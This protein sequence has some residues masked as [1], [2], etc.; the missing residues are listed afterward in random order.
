MILNM[1][2]N[3]LCSSLNWNS[4]LK[5]L[6]Y[7]GPI[8][9]VE[10]L[11]DANI[12]SLGRLLWV[13]P[14]SI[15]KSP[16][17]TRFFQ[18]KEG[19][20][21]RGIGKIVRYQSRPNFVMRGNKSPNLENVTIIVQDVYSEEDIS[22]VWFNCYKSVSN[23]LRHCN[24]IVFQGKVRIYKNSF[25]IT[26]PTFEEVVKDDIPSLDSLRE[27]NN[28]IIRYP[29]IN[30]VQGNQIKKIFDAIPPRPWHH[31]EDHVP[32]DI[33]TKRSLLPLGESFQ[34]LHGKSC[35]WSEDL[36]GKAK[37]RMIYQ[38][39]FDEQIKIL[40][41]KRNNN[42]SPS[43]PITVSDKMMKEFKA[44]FP[45]VLT[46][47][48]HKAVE[49]IRQ[50]L[51]SCRPMMRLIQGDVGCGKT[52]VAV[53][54]ALMVCANQHQSALMCP[55]ESLAY[56]HFLN[57]SDF[58]KNSPYKVGL[59][60]GST[61]LKEKKVLKQRL[62]E[63]EIHLI[64]GTHSLIQDSVQFQSLALAVIDEQHKFGVNQRV[65]LLQKTSGCHCLIMSATPIPRS[66]RLTQYGDLDITTIK[67]M[68][69]GRRG[70][71]TRIVT[72]KTFRQ[73]LSFVKT[74]LSMGEQGLVVVPTIEES[75]VLDVENLEKTLSEYSKL[76]F[77]YNVAG[78]HGQLKAQE[79]QEIFQNFRYHHID[80]LVAT[81]VVEV[82]I[83]VPNA[84]VMSILNPERFGLS[85]LHQLRGRIG[86]GEKMGFCFLVSSNFQSLKRLRIVE[87]YTDGLK[88]AEEDLK[89]RGEGDLFGTTQS[90]EASKR[91]MANIV[92]HQREL[93]CAR[94]DVEEVIRRD[95]VLYARSFQDYGQ[96]KLVLQTI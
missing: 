90:G 88:I 69:K 17:V 89:I 70:Y 7:K 71:K 13:F 79:K 58:L 35:P 57:I 80:L 63:G 64:V 75:D 54:A 36:L 95:P 60:V 67:T 41:R 62:R 85:S 86:R 76:F 94:E 87:K 84:T 18:L 14:N 6:P 50:D 83:D 81:S 73:F 30:S 68:P 28:L 12:T 44:V 48:Q 4:S 82:G 38:E 19:T 53:L 74:R 40:L 24:Y 26:N 45:Y 3:P 39:F 65:K 27:D 59:L 11:F 78:V 22:L 52:C 66:L 93:V 2:S 33:L 1:K 61:P 46:D 25:Q 51:Q 55:T 96:E 72:P 34:I 9:N 10:K 29:T 47:D 91:K 92:L 23:I 5:D 15:T 8:V 49:D 16:P 21:F 43:I 20:L 32:K 31:I 56:Q 77:E 37:K 42:H